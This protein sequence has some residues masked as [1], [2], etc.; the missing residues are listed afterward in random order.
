MDRYGLGLNCGFL[1][2]NHISV[3]FRL[4]DCTSDEVQ[5]AGGNVR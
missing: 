2:K 1:P 3:S 5:L 4:H